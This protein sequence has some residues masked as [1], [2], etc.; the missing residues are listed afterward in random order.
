MQL[1]ESFVGVDIIDATGTLHH[2]ELYDPSLGIVGQFL[3][4]FN[5]LKNL[6]VNQFDLD[7]NQVKVTAPDLQIQCGKGGTMVPGFFIDDSDVVVKSF[8][9][10]A[11]QGN[12]D[13]IEVDF[14]TKDC[15]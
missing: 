5:N 12:S 1:F 4:I 13:P 2:I 10:N 8:Y 11:G 15:Q 14:H 6:L 7:P 3:T 9:G